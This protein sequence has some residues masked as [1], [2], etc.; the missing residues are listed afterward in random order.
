MWVVDAFFF[1]LI[2]TIIEERDA[3]AVT[4]LDISKVFNSDSSPKKT[5]MPWVEI[6]SYKLIS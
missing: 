5:K 3:V 1:F 6:L 4:Y 2:T